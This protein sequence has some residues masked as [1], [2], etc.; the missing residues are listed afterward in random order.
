MLK[1]I[2]KRITP[3]AAIATLAL[4]LAMTGGAYA[5]KKYLITSTKQI[6]PSVLG[7]LKGKPGPAGAPGAGGVGSAGPAGPQGPAGGGGAK[8]ET[9]P[10]GSP[11]PQGAKGEPGERGEPGE[12]GEAG[13]PGP[14]GKAGFVKTLPHGET[15]TGTFAAFFSN[16]T[17]GFAPSPISFPIPL[18][19][20]LEA[21]ATHHVT[22]AEQ[23]KHT[24]PPQCTGSVA[25][26]TA[27]KGNLCVYEGESL[28]SEA[29]KHLL[30]I[31]VARPAAQSEE[32]AG[33]AGA[34]LLVSYEGPAEPAYL[35]GSWA[36]SAP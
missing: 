27:E 30:I 29:T 10:S 11:G 14:E 22:L 12:K 23:E 6:S 24:G 25:K 4:V 20:A 19:I 31:G 1:A 15:E 35:A 8:G 32:G 26:P 5:A 2:R 34:V 36:V 13:E 7:A 9:G 16:V 3:S 33:T 18:P 28:E 21:G 17:E